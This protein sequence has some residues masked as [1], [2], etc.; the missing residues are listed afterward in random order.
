MTAITSARR[1]QGFG[2][3]EILVGV[4]IGV[5]GILI[6]FQTLAV[7]EG[8]NRTASTGNDAQVTGS[9]AMFSL[10]RDLKLAGLGFG[11]ASGAAPMVMGCNVAATDTL[12]GVERI[13]NFNLV[14]V[15]IVQDAG[16]GPDRIRVLYGNSAYLNVTNGDPRNF[17]SATAFTTTLDETRTRIGFHA[18]DLAIMA[19]TAVVPTTCAMVQVT[20]EGGGRTFAHAN[21]NYQNFY[22]AAAAPAIPSRFNAAVGAGAAFV[23]GPVYNLGPDPRRNEWRVNGRVLMVSDLIHNTADFE[24]AEDVIDLRAQYGLDTNPAAGVTTIAWGAAAPADWSQVRAVRVAMLVRGKQFERPAADGGNCIT[25][26]APAWAAGAFLM[27]N[28]DGTADAFAATDAVPN[29]WRCY[30]YRVDEKVIPLRNMIWGT[31][32]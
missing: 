8:R 25:T 14:P 19:N 7:W 23:S 5:V 11:S 16:G 17:V 24:V 31:A 10:E 30:R 15:E 4:V 22:E 26:V 28:V 18:G 9:L 20:D 29:N 12:G 1:Q 2:L 27:R 32:P 21:G 13:F 3:I 6:M